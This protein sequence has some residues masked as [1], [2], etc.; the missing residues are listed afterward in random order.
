[1]SSTR[2][3]NVNFDVKE[4]TNKDLFFDTLTISNRRIH[5]LHN[6]IT[7]GEMEPSFE[8]RKKEVNVSR[9]NDDGTEDIFWR[10]VRAKDVNRFMNNF[11]KIFKHN[12]TSLLY[13][14]PFLASSLMH[15]LFIRIHPYTDGNGRTSRIIHNIK[16]TEMVN[17][18]YGTNLKLSPLNLSESILLNKVTY[19]K[20]LDNIYFDMKHDTNEDI[21]A[22][23]NFILD[24]ADEQLFVAIGRIPS[25][26]NR[27]IVND[28][29]IKKIR[30]MRLSKIK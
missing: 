11:I 28:N 25:I 29:D 15:L 23:F 27:F 2:I 1:M 12:C 9:I 16:F 13:S 21:N 6:F 3:E 30:S 8:Y 17:K 18:L 22:W 5:L 24:M 10:G 7:E 14:N 26:D 20:R 19:V 4:L